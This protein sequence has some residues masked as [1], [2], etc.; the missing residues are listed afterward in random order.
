MQTPSFTFP[1]LPGDREHLWNRIS[2]IEIAHALKISYCITAS[3]TQWS[4]TCELQ[5]F[6]TLQLVDIKDMDEQTHMFG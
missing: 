2:H 6:I 4:A 5:C 3:I 1:I